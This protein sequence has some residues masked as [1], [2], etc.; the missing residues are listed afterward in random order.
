[1]SYFDII[2][3]PEFALLTP[4]LSRER[5]ET[6]STRGGVSKLKYNNKLFGSIK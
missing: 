3:H 2:T 6:T 5:G 1:M 4:P